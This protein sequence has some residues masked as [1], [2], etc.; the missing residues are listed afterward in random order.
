MMTV[1][2]CVVALNEEKCLP[3][4]LE[5]IKNQTYRHD[6]I[7]VVLIDGLSTDKTKIIMQE[8]AQKESSFISVKVLDNPKKIQATGW[9]IAIENARG[10]VVIRID[11]HSHLP[12]DFV[13]KNMELQESGEMV[14]GGP[15][16]CIIENTSA[17]KETI[18]EVEN[19]LFGSS[20]N[21]KINVEEKTYVKTM[22]HAAYRREVFEKAGNFNENLLR[23]EDNELHYRIGKAGYKFCYSPEIKSYQ[24]ARGNF[25]KMVKQKFGNG[26]SV[27]ST[28]WVC[29]GCLSLFYFVPFFF[30][31]G[32]IAT[33]ILSILGFWHS[34]ALMWGLYLLFTFYGTACTIINKK[35]NKWTFLTPILFLILHISYGV[36][37]FI[38]IFKFRRFNTARSLKDK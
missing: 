36:G 7:E 21:R 26:K 18:L 4:L 16:P 13:E 23:T 31:L 25:R 8:F 28:L 38:G 15:R 24:Y 12:E 5:D 27:G 14:T 10:E 37:T 11:A 2:I 22:F 29:P 20:I 33:T 17:W 32:I 9:N 35:A 3:Q 19:S 34:S 1:S 6:L 30:V